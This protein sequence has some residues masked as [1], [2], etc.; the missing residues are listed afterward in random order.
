MRGTFDGRERR[1]DFI[2][3]KRDGSLHWSPM[4]KTRSNKLKRVGMLTYD[5]NDR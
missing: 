1:E 2:V 3:I 5:E 4:A